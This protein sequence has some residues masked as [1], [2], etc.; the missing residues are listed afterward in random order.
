MK[1]VYTR[2]NVRVAK[3][4]LPRDPKSGKRTLGKRVNRMYEWR[5]QAYG[6]VKARGKG[7]VKDDVRPTNIQDSLK[8]EK[9]NTTSKWIV[10]E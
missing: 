3:R 8:K 1:S 5:D 7:E 9:K 2:Y 6:D 10:D 4:V